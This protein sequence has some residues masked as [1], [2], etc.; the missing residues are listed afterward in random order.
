MTGLVSHLAGHAAEDCVARV[1]IELG[2]TETQ[3]CWRGPAGEID[4]ILS[5][6]DQTVF[7]EVKKARDIATAAERLS[8]RQLRRIEASAAD[9]LGRLPLG[10]ATDARID[11]ALVDETGQVEI[12]ENVTMH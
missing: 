11:V 5:R 4:L 6:G 3:R 8:A 10:Q 12:L 2:Y 7:V 9:F 1:Y